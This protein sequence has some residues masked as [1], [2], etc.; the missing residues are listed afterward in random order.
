M[1]NINLRQLRAF[2]TIGVLGS[3]TRA[4]DALH[5]TQ[6]ALS[7]QIR[8]LEAELGLRLFDRNTRSVSPTQA[9]RDLLPIVEKILADIGVVAAHAQNVVQRN[10]GRIAIAAL[11]SVSSTLLPQAVVRFRTQFPGV[12]VAL[13]DS[14]AEGIVEMIRNDDVDFGVTS[15]PASDAQLEFT[16]LASDRMVALLPRDHPLA[17]ARRLRLADLLDTPLILMNRDSS[18]RRIVD[19]ACVSLGRMATPA[20]EPAFMATAIGMVRAGLG[21]TLLPSSALEIAAAADLVVQKLDAPE[22]TRQI[23]VLRKR[24]RSLSPAADSFVGTLRTHAREW[25]SRHLRPPAR[26]YRPAGKR[27]RSDGER[28]RPR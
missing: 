18:V 11:P 3:F 27:T 24:T 1:N 17:S 9:G 20:Y 21:A 25:F 4:A 13:K 22:L 26:A 14:L 15:S 28:A 7:A 2:M 8:E 12:T 6:P 19:A 23:G 10:I 5:T 16:P